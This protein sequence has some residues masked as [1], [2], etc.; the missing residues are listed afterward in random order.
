MKKYTREETFKELFNGVN[1]SYKVHYVKCYLNEEEPDV[2]YILEFYFDVTRIVQN[3]FGDIVEQ[4]FLNVADAYF[5]NDLVDE[6]EVESVHQ[7][8][9][10][11]NNSLKDNIISFD[12]ETVYIKFINGKT[13]QFSA[14]E[15]GSIKT[16]YEG[17]KEFHEIG[18]N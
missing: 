11:A 16:P 15:N 12:D 2:P 10:W 1:Y 6:W 3:I 4:A 5:Y 7:S 13:V 9:D 18:G 8:L 14:T 17:F